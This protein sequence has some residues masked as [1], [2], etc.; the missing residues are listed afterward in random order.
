[1]GMYDTFVIVG[2]SE[3]KCA[4]GHP[5]TKAQSKDLGCDLD[6]YYLFDGELWSGEIRG[7]CA[8]RFERRGDDLV[9]VNERELHRVVLTDTVE[10]HT[11]CNAC[12]P[13]YILKGPGSW[14][15]ERTDKRR[16]WVELLLTFA[17]GKL[18][19]VEPSS[20]SQTR[21]QLRAQLVAGGSAVLADNDPIIA[22]EKVLREAGR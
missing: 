12:D 7:G 4:H 2:S 3:L 11:E 8:E 1:M 18:V 10:I 20:A 14:G 22:A 19:G 6:T 16:P 9:C 17:K 21:D 5:V 15:G 13:V